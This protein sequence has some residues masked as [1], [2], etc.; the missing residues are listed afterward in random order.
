M[1]IRK[2][3]YNTLWITT[4]LSVTI[5]VVCA[6]VS[7]CNGEQK[8]ISNAI[9]MYGSYFGGIATLAAAYIASLLFNKWQDQHNKNIES[10]LILNIVEKFNNFDDKLSYFYGP[11]SKTYNREKIE[12]SDPVFMSLN[13]NKYE[14]LFE[15]QMQFLKVIDAIEKYSI[16]EGNYE[17]VH[18]D[19]KKY[20]SKFRY[21]LKK[22]EG[23]DYSNILS[24]RDILSLHYG[25]LVEV[26]NSFEQNYVNG[27]LIKL[28]E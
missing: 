2:S 22:C 18:E 14:I 6:I 21:F 10:S 11:I 26:L 20:K 17:H 19:L 5:I 28:K 25:E 4:A 12:A 16:V 9:T 24:S 8:P 13:D 15:L 23:I 7:G 3:I 1:D 27:L